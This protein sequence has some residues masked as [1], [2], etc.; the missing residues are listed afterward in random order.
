MT[1][2]RYELLCPHCGV[3]FRS[4]QKKK[5]CSQRCYVTSPELKEMLTRESR[6]AWAERLGRPVGVLEEWICL[7]CGEKRLLRQAKLKRRRFCNQ[8]CYRAY[9]A[10]RFDRFIANPET[11]AL[12]QCYDEFLD[13]DELP[14]LVN[15]C[16]WV[17]KHLGS[18]VN[19]AH[20]ITAEQFKEMAGFN[21]GTGLVSKDLAKTMSDRWQQ[22]NGPPSALAGNHEPPITKPGTIR[23]E[24]REHLFRAFALG[25]GA[26]LQKGNK[27]YHEE[28]PNWKEELGAKRRKD[29]ADGTGA[30]QRVHSTCTMCGTDFLATITQAKKDVR[31]CSS[32]C[33]RR[34]HNENWVARAIWPMKCFQCGKDFLGTY[35]QNKSSKRGAPT[36][37]DKSCVAARQRVEVPQRF[38]KKWP[39]TCAQCSEIFLGNQAQKAGVKRGKKLRC[40]KCRVQHS[41]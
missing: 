9:M 11:I 37:C 22:W 34:W 30:Y 15:G 32:D 39:L 8:V 33:G 27:K 17:G 18:H 23:L 7:E 12:P 14:C 1:D 26:A 29:A 16:T 21:R 3:L 6:K 13:R 31:I 4:R 38:V 20:G 28:N 2:G 35:A 5:Y 40:E 41:V 10:A 19:F 25:T 24:G 36:Y